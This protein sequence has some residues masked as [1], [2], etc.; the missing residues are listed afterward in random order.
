MTTLANIASATCYVEYATA[1]AANYIIR[2]NTWP[3]APLFNNFHYHEG[4]P[5]TN[6]IACI[7][8]VN[9]KSQYGGGV[10]AVAAPLRSSAVSNVCRILRRVL[11]PCLF[12]GRKLRLRTDSPRA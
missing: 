1:T 9:V 6:D 8:Y 4:S 5:D 3:N 12:T 10:P 11:W 2:I 7:T